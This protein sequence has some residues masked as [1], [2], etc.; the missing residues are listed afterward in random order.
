MRVIVMITNIVEQGKRKCEQYWPEVGTECYGV[1][2]VAMVEE[3]VQVTAIRNISLVVSLSNTKFR[4]IRHCNWKLDYK[5][6][7][8]C[9]MNI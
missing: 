9:I 5:L 2:D 4:I 1:I 8:L 6:D 3:N 7:Q